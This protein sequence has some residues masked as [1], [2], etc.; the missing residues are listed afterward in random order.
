MSRIPVDGFNNE[1]LA[2]PSTDLRELI[3]GLDPDGD[4]RVFYLEGALLTNEHDSEWGEAEF[5]DS[6][7]STATTYTGLQRFGPIWVPPRDNVTLIFPG[8]GLRFVTNVVVGVTNGTFPAG[9]SHGW[10][11]LE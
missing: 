2:A 8:K 1:A 3:S 4:G 7:E 5:Y 6:N 10:G 9:G 11:H